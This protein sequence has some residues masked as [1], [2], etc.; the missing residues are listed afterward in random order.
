MSL[1]LL[2]LVDFAVGQSSWCDW[3]RCIYLGLVSHLGIGLSLLFGVVA[4]WIVDQVCLLSLVPSHW[5]W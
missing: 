4:E 3:V 5:H 2:V 1:V